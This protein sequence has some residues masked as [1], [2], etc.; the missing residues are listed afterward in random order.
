M[1]DRQG[2]GLVREQVG[3]DRPAGEGNVLEP[4]P[5]GGGVEQVAGVEQPRQQHDAGPRQ[6]ARHVP[7]GRE[8]GR[9]GEHDD[10]HGHRLDGREAGLARGQAVDEPEPDRR[11]GDPD[12]LGD[13]P[14]AT[15]LEVRG[16]GRGP[17]VG[18][19]ELAQRRKVF[20]Q[21]PS[22]TT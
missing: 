10:A 14:A 1:A 7:D 4:R 15:R 9:P 5:Q 8:L 16:G 19:R 21:V 11:D 17:V 3:H 12:A 6:A 13:Q 22:Q 2:E 18:R 20:A